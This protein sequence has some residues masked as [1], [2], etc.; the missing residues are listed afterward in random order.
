MR[1]LVIDNYDSFTYNL[2]AMIRLLGHSPEV[3][4]N[5][6]IHPSEAG[7]F[8]KIILSPGPGIPEEAGVMK[9]V[10]ARWCSVKSILG[11]CLGH[12]GIAEVFGARIYNMPTVLHGTTSMLTVCDPN[13]RLFRGLPDEFMVTH[14]HS[15]AMVPKEVPED[16]AITAVNS[17][18]VVMAISHKHWD[19]HGVQFH[20]ESFRTEQGMGIMKNWLSENR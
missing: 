13:S 8:D 10:I 11:V 19:V 9:E 18:G 2:V 15:W 14:Y 12:Q 5:D 7:G 4:L 20:P 3:V 17:S 16:L 1:I 6:R